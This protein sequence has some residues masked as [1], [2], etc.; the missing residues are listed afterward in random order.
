MI[1]KGDKVRMA[2]ENVSEE[3]RGKVF[4]VSSYPFTVDGVVSVFLKEYPL[5]YPVEGLEKAEG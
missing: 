1:L 5:A 3:N 4:K 2:G